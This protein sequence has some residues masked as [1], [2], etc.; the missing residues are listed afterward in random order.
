MRS[1][2]MLGVP[3]GTRAAAPFAAFVPTAVARQR[4]PYTAPVRRVVPEPHSSSRK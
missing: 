3:T 4:E 1:R 2:R